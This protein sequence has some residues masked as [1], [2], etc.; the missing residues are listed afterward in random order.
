MVINVRC[1]EVLLSPKNIKPSSKAFKILGVLNPGAARLSDG[2]IILYVR[3]IEKL[4]KTEDDKYYYAP[5]MVGK[6]RFRIKID[7]FRKSLIEDSGE[8]EIIFKDGTK[9]LFFISHLR[10]VILDR[11]GLKVLSID[12]KPSFYGIESDGELS[13]E[14]PRIT[15]I[16]DL[17]IM[18]YVSLS[19]EQN[20][21]TAL[22]VSDDCINWKRK[23][24]IFGEQDKD[25]VIF[26]EKVN[27]KYIAFDRPEG[28]FQFSQPHI[29]IAYSNDLKSWGNL[30]PIG[31]VYEE[32]GFCPRNGA[33]PPPIKTKR[34]WLLLYHA[35]TEFREEE[36]EKEILRKLR[37]I[38]KLKEGVVRKIASLNEEV[39]KKIILYSVGGALFDLENPEKLI[40]KSKSFLI[41]PDNNHD[42]NGFENKRVVFPTGLVVDENGKDLLVYSGGADVVTTVRK[43]RLDAILKSLEKV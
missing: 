29:W 20:V 22:A 43:I 6:D 15:K 24:I 32:N 33:G 12:K 2:R 30:K 13:V 37:K 39:I 31:N 36:Q 26:P 40:A 14:D 8:L 21:S 3:V 42:S 9:R 27:G 1:E 11:S 25:V 23:G 41:V 4:R 35:V 28:N 38:V 16:G 5:R 18:T 10:K 19:R 17:Y 34:G 7:R